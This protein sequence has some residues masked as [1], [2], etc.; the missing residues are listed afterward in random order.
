MNVVFIIFLLT[1]FVS[2]YQYVDNASWKELQNTIYGSLFEKKNKKYGAYKIQRTQNITLSI[3]LG[4]FLL[5]VVG[6]VFARKVLSALDGPIESMSFSNIEDT[7]QF[8]LSNENLVETPPS[9][10]NFDGDNGDGQNVA[11]D[12]AEKPE[13]VSNEVNDASEP[14]EA[15][16]EKPKKKTTAEQSIYDFEKDLYAQT[17]GA[18]ERAKIQKEMDERKKQRELKKQQQK[19][20]GA[21]G[22]NIG[23]N[24]GSQGQT[25]AEWN[26]N[27]RKPHQNNPDFVKIPG[28]M[29]GKGV[30][31]KVVVKV[32]VN[33]NGDVISAESQAPAGTNPCCVENAERYAKRSRFEYAST[34]IQEGT[35]TYSFK[36]Q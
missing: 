18:E 16:V 28:Y 1:L 22:G 21:N 25:L 15:P 26:L 11:K 6:S 35:I 17:G 20:D 14:A 12:G 23:S 32:K 2:L 13:E 27:G 4:V 33:S 8:T 24:A 31:V 9:Q 30:N 29:C 5:L 36:A 7:T 34:P 10:F 19:V 3:V